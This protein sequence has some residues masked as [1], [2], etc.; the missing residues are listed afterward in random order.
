MKRA[1]GAGLIVP[2]IVLILVGLV[3]QSDILAG[4]INIVGWLII[5]GGAIMCVFGLI[6]AFKGGNSGSSDY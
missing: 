4:L 5:I 1:G 3:I 6:R 2:G